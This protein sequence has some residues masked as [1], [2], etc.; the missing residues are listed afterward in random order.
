MA[1]KKPVPGNK[2]AEGVY[3]QI[4]LDLFD[5]RLLPGD[6]FTETEVAE[7]MGVSRTP[8]RQALYKLEKEGHIQVSSRNGWNVRPFDF[9]F[10]EDLYDVRVVLELAAV[11]RLCE[12]EPRPDLSALKQIWLVPPEQRVTDMQTIATLDERFHEGLVLAAG[13]AEMARIHHD[14]TERIR[15]VRRLDFT[16]PE[17]IA[18]TYQE[19][20]QILR[21]VLQRKWNRC[22]LLL[23]S[24]IES[25][26]AEVRKIT[27]HKL[28]TARSTLHKTRV[29]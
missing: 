21:N 28:H 25:S 17:R 24:H 13:N 5:F 18:T 26:K 16:R 1:K 4:K 23:R 19:H 22:E 8:V 2:L 14:V 12:M 11:K 27:L 20:A 7:R 29:A 9:E 3:E 6:R 15:I 10:L